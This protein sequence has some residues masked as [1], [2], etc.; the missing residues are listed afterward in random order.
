[1]LGDDECFQLQAASRAFVYM[2]SD[3]A[4]S[5]RLNQVF[6][7]RISYPVIM[8]SKLPSDHLL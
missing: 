5:R 8:L 2:K 7:F 4:A 1:M 3:P 6:F